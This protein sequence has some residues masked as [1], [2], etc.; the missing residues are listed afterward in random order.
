MQKLKDMKQAVTITEQ[1]E[2]TEKKEETE[3]RLSYNMQIDSVLR[4]DYF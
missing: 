2:K 1:L 3:Q 4:A